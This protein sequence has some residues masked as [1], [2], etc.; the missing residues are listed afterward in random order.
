MGNYIIALSRQLLLGKIILQVVVWLFV[1]LFVLYSSWGK[2][3]KAH[4]ILNLRKIA[5][6][7]L[8]K[9]KSLVS[10][11]VVVYTSNVT[12]SVAFNL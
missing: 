5:I 3:K 1:W 4:N 2:K 7:Y 10:E 9:K 12:Q 6:S 8:K 11:D